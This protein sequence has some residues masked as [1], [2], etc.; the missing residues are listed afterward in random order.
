[1]RGCECEGQGGGSGVFVRACEHL[2]LCV[3]GDVSGKVVLGQSLAVV[4]FPKLLVHP[5]HPPR[6]GR[7]LSHSSDVM[8]LVCGQT[9]P[10]SSPPRHQHFLWPSQSLII[11]KEITTL[12]VAFSITDYKQR[13]NN[14]SCGLLHH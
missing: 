2:I 1:M 4:P 7:L 12:P 6:P 8:V 5:A 13:N 10:P 11:N 14:T 9:P 3:V